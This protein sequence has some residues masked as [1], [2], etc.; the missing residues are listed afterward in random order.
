MKK[1][2]LALS[3]FSSLSLIGCSHFGH[4]DHCD[5]KSEKCACKSEGAC[6][7]DKMKAG[8]AD[9]ADKEKKAEETK[10]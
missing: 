2:I 10:K 7:H 3:L 5:K 6:D 8:C 4:C 9:C 1:I